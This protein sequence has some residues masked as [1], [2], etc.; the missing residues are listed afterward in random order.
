[1]GSVRGEDEAN[2]LNRV[3]EYLIDGSTGGVSELGWEHCYGFSEQDRQELLTLLI[4]AQGNADPNA[5]PD[6]VCENGAIEHFRVSAS[7][8]TRKGQALL[9]SRA[10]FEMKYA[11]EKERVEKEAAENPGVAC[12]GVSL[13]K[14]PERSYEFLV[15]SLKKVFDKHSGSLDRY[16]EQTDKGSVIAYMIECNELSLAMI[17]DM[18]GEE[19]QGYWFGDLQRQESCGCYRLSRDK[20]ALE[21]I[22]KWQSKIDYVIFVTPSSVETIRLSSIPSILKLLPFDYRIKPTGGTMEVRFIAGITVPASG[23][24]AGDQSC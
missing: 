11:E 16:L 21:W 2:C 5:F 3:R 4:S 13:L 24:K 15:D 18:F 19:M 10:T 20:A 12:K 17:E 14:Y 1:M 6:F 7:K 8:T 22:S 23:S 9:F